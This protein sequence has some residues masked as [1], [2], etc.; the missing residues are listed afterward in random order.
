[1]G[2]AL[3]HPTYSL[4]HSSV[5]RYNSSISNYDWNT[6]MVQTPI[7]TITLEAFLAMPET[8]PASEFIDGEISQ[9]PMPQGKH[10]IVQGE[11]VPA[12][13]VLKQSK[14]ARAF[15]E[16]R[17]VFGGRATVPDIAVFTWARI[18]RDASGAVANAFTIAP[19]WTIEILSPDQSQTKVVKNIIHCLRHGALMGWLIDPEEQTV[20]VYRPQHE[21]EIFDL[22]EQVLPV[23]DFATE[24]PLTVGELFGWLVE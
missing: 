24:L 7:K 2:F 6:A 15:P 22:S 21:V 9:K 11:L 17:C 23:P 3:L 20:F 10:S 18:P 4:P 16:L 14:T 12:I 19:D 1:L 8:Q 13:N 5:R